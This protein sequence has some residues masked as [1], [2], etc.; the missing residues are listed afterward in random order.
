MFAAQK[1]TLLVLPGTGQVG[2]SQQVF[3]PISHP[4]GGLGGVGD[5]GGFN[6]PYKYHYPLVN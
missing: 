3:D 2:S 4:E 6:P 5:V 1:V